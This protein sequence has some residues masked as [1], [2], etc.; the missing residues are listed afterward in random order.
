[1]SVVLSTH[2]GQ[3]G[4]LAQGGFWGERINKFGENRFAS[5]TLRGWFEMN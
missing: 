1:M 2:K 5:L 4:Q 3:R